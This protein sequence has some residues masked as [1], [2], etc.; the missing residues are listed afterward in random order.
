M[1]YYYAVA[2]ALLSGACAR[3]RA[4][5]NELPRP[6][7]TQWTASAGARLHAL[8]QV[9]G[10]CFSRGVGETFHL[11]DYLVSVHEA[12][13]PRMSLTEFQQ[14]LVTT[15]DAL[16][17]HVLLH[18]RFTGLGSG[19]VAD[20][21]SLASLVALRR[22]LQVLEFGTCEGASTWHLWANA[23][24]EATITTLDIPPETQVV[25]STDL[26]LQG[27]R[28]RPLLPDDSRVRLIEV[29]SRTWIPDVRD[30]DFCFIDAGH[31]Y[32]C[33]K[34]DTE[35]AFAVMRP[36]GLIV[37]HDASWRRDGYAVNDYLRELRAGGR[38]VVLLTPGS[39]DLCV[40]AALVV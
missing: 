39:L 36:G 15:G 25:G 14:R 22:P 1:R 23:P 35:K 7:I 20:M 13:L 21:A 6:R 18:P 27:L 11:L 10:L 29:D 5:T 16:P 12:G 17:P 9:V 38:D 26:E 34:N 37:W 28:S 2:A 19:T 40:L 33:V 30:V 32:E 3:Q 24:P 4:R 8:R 31:S